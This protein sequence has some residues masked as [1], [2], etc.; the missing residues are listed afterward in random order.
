MPQINATDSLDPAELAD[1]IRRANAEISV[2][3]AYDDARR[4]MGH[5]FGNGQ[6]WG[7]IARLERDRNELRRHLR[8]PRPS[9]LELA[10]P[11]ELVAE[12]FARISAERLARYDRGSYL[13]AT[14]N[15]ARRAWAAAERRLEEVQS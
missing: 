7:E 14:V 13:V 3:Q 12:T 2:L 9:T 15:R 11:P 4:S 6:R 10:A 8:E 1:K 5:D